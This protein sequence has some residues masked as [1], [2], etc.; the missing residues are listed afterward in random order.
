MKVRTRFAPSPTGFLHIGSLRTALFSYTFAHSQDGQFLLRIEDTDQ[1]RLVPGAVEGICKMLKI[2][3]L[4]W[5]E[6]P[7]VGGPY[8]PYIQSERVQKGIYQKYVQELIKAGQAYYCFCPP[9]TKEEIEAHHQGKKLELRNQC[10]FLS[11]EEVE[12][13]LKAGEKAAIRLRVPDSETVSYSD[14]VLKKEISWETKD[15]DEV[16]LLKSDGYPTYHLAVVVDDA[17]MKISHIIRGRDW[18]PSTPVHLLLFKYLGFSLP[19]VGHLT[20]ILDPAGGKLSK[21]KGSV[22]CEEFLA[23]GYLPEAILN[24]IMLLGWAPKDNRELFTLKEFVENF[25]KGEL[26]TAN[27]VFNRKKLDWF[28]GVYLR[29]KSDEEL[30]ILVRPFAPKGMDDELIKKTIPLVKERLRKLSDYPELVEFL[31]KEPKV[32]LGLLVEKSGGSKELVKKQLTASLVLL[33]GGALFEP[34]VLEQKF[35]DLVSQNNWHLGNY[36]MSLR[37][38]VTGKTQTP[39]LFASMALLGKIKTRA[40][41]QSAI[42]LLS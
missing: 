2:F 33:D 17:L 37:L 31:A 14:F 42:K 7:E 39:P 21:R 38:V 18:L 24:F 40:R 28:N 23:E 11:P 16:T 20:D 19:E 1:K 9:E 26:Q 10:R 27:P 35:R 32:D 25:P 36:F 29:Q 3:G 8:K 34:E 12:K 41:L 5:D 30:F 13:R 6:G 22:T 15:V 4:N